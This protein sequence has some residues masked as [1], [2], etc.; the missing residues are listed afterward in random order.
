MSQE[1]DGS[2][3]SINV[4]RRHEVRGRAFSAL[5]R[6][7]MMGRLIDMREHF[8]GCYLPEYPFRLGFRAA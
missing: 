7:P 1:R 6:D 5:S 2:C 8:E 4:V 3:L